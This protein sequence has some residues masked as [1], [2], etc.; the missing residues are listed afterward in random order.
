MKNKK[1]RIGT[2]ESRLA[3]W[4]AK[5]FQRQLQELGQSSELVLIKSQGDVLSEVSFRE[6][7]SLNVGLFTHTLIDAMRSGKID[8]AVHSLKDLPTQ[9]PN[10]V[11][12]SA[13]LPRSDFRDL[14][15]YRG[16]HHFLDDFS[17]KATIAT[18][19][20]RRSA[21]WHYRYPQ[22]EIVDLRGNIDTRLRKLVQSRWDGAIFAVAGLK[23]I[24]LLEELSAR[25][26]HY[27]ELNWML[28]APAQGTIAA[29]LMKEN[30]ELLTLCDRLSHFET[31]LT[32][33][34]ERRFLRTLEGGC[35]MPIGARALLINQKI[36]FQGALIS[37]DGKELIQ[38]DRWGP[39]SEILGEECAYEVFNKGG[40][41]LMKSITQ[42]SGNV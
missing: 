40:R 41:A 34:A 4:Q 3:L 29:T 25:G 19:S 12:L 9:L 31:K 38:V 36:H 20:L 28:S 37:T 26:F 15:I 7:S 5:C 1:I 27:K 14:L 8:T 23:R 6:L 13:Y 2:R 17:S 24:G 42:A 39:M 33:E 10:N 16:S 11:V 35:S 21:F 22:H 32:S 30:S 18:G